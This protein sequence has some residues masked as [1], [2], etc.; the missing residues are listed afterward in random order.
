MNPLHIESMYLN[1]WHMV[2]DAIVVKAAGK[3][4]GQPD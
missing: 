4:V 3:L 2:A 1:E